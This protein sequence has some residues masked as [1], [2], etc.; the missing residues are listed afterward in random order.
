VKVPFSRTINLI[1]IRFTGVIAAFSAIICYGEE[2]PGKLQS[3]LIYIRYPL[4]VITDGIV[5][6]PV[7]GGENLLPEKIR[8]APRLKHS[9]GILDAPV[10]DIR[11]VFRRFGLRLPENSV[12]IY[13]PRSALLFVKSTQNDL[14]LVDELL[15]PRD[16]GGRVTFTWDIRVNKRVA[17]GES[18]NILEAKSLSLISGRTIELNVSGKIPVH[19]SLEPVVGPDGETWQVFLDGSVATDKKTIAIKADLQPKTSRHS[20]VSLGKFDDGNVEVGIEIHRNSE[21]VGP[22]ALQT[23]ELKAAAIRE[24]ES[25]LAQ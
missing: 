6:D 7:G 14:E 23:K 2:V 15:K 19:L 1:S 20:A 16:S 5:A 10:Y 11:D 4:H 8:L 21:W 22:P 12:A 25:A 9:S 18:E 17:D 3:D 24:I 13:S